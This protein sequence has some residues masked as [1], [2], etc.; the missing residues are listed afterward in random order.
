VLALALP[1]AWGCA[2]VLGF[3]RDYR[4][5]GAGAGSGGEPGTS[6]GTGD[7]TGS[8]PGVTVTAG[9]GDTMSIPATRVSRKCDDDTGCPDPS[10]PRCC[11]G[12]CA[13]VVAEIAGGGHHFC[14]RKSDGTLWCWGYNHFGQL[15]NGDK[16]GGSA[17]E[18]CGF[19][20][21]LSPVQVS[22]LGDTVR[23]VAAGGYFTCAIDAQ[24]A[25]WCWGHN[26]HG[27]VG[28][29]TKAYASRPVHV[30]DGAIDVTAGDAHAC[31]L[32]SDHLVRCWGSNDKGQLGNGTT[33]STPVPMHV[34]DLDWTESVRAG[35]DHT[36]ALMWDGALQCW[37]DNHDGQLGNGKVTGEACSDGQATCEL[38]PVRVL[39]PPS[40][41][42]YTSFAS[43]S[44]GAH[45]TCAF[46]TDRTA[47]CWGSTASGALGLGDT[48]EGNQDCG[49]P[50]PCKPV[51]RQVTALGKA[52][53]VIESGSDHACAIERTQGSLWCWG[54]NKS[55]QLGDG[56]LEDRASPVRISSLGDTVV[57]VAA[58]SEQTCVLEKD[59][60]VWCWGRNDNGELGDGTADGDVACENGNVCK[61]SPVR[62]EIGECQ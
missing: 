19:E 39:Q 2:Q 27:Q 55:G 5:T 35:S 30:A 32:F 45:F 13:P 20:C 12:S 59:H 37:G 1:A 9:P 34:K 56:T 41:S 48:T 6:S 29:D 36:C 49:A 62:A 43:A 52:F 8:E 15:G 26:N 42:A 33:W 25:L 47:W 31:A 53:A 38:S 46:M 40:A 18:A 28:S 16:G 11:H 22:A 14:A 44:P 61:K 51:P 7:T 23:K 10:K 17:D 57:A 54:H 60:T 24:G 58:G 21:R 3:D 50:A 4:S